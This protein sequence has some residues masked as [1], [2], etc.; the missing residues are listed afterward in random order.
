MDNNSITD[1]SNGKQENQSQLATDNQTSPVH[2]GPP[3][4][5]QAMMR[6]FLKD[7]PT[8]MAILGVLAGI[9]YYIYSQ[10]PWLLLTFLPILF[11]TGSR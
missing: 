3:S 9:G 11:G 7:A 2:H 1:K 10:N 6:I 4:R 8:L 5:K